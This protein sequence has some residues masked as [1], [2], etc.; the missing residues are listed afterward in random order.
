MLTAYSDKALNRGYTAEKT[1]FDTSVFQS[2]IGENEAQG[3]KHRFF[4]F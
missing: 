2:A 4:M 3:V 1:M